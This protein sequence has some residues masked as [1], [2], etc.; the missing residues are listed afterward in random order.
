MPVAR[1]VDGVVR[2]VWFTLCYKPIERVNEESTQPISVLRP[3]HGL[4]TSFGH[5]LVLLVL[6]RASMFSEFEGVLA[7]NVQFRRGDADHSA[8]LSGRLRRPRAW[9]AG[10]SEDG[11]LLSKF[12]V[13]IM[14]ESTATSNDLS[15]FRIWKSTAH[16]S[17]ALA[18]AYPWARRAR[19][20]PK[21]LFV[22]P[23]RPPSPPRLALPTTKN[24]QNH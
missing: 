8:S 17:R 5:V 22:L 23:P 1:I 2:H 4:S 7:R 11:W 19:R 3:V 21:K 9:K 24:S 20:C 18:V 10:P 14:I 6:L 13:P 15:T 16:C 12:R